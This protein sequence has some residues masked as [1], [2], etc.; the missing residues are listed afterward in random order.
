MRL[1]EV[2]GPPSVRALLGS[3]KF[4]INKYPSKD[5]ALVSQIL[6][7]SASGT[8]KDKLPEAIIGHV[9]SRQAYTHSVKLNAMDNI[10]RLRAMIDEI[11]SKCTAILTPSAPGDAP[12][13]YNTGSPVFNTFWTVGRTHLSVIS[14][15]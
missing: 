11:L 2:L 3:H 12:A 15:G 13:G 7:K 1:W 6:P 4:D 5:H 9:E 10:S 8:D 14:I